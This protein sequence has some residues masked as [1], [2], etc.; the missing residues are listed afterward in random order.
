MS[1]ANEPDFA[2]CGSSI[3]PPCNGDYD[4]MVYTANE[5]VAWVKM[6]GPKLHT[7]GVKLMAPEPSEWLH[8]WSN[9]FLPRA[10][11]VASHQ[12]S[13]DPLGCGCFAND[14]TTTGCAS[15]CTTGGGYDYG[16]SGSPRI[17]RRG[18]CRHCGTH[19]Y[20]TQQALAWPSD[21]DGGKRSKEV[22][23]TEMSGVMYWPEQ[24][25]S[26]DINNGIAVA[27]W[28][29][30]ALVVGQASAWLYW[31]YQPSGPTTTRAWSP[32]AQ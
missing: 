10:R 19:E 7:A 27:G 16:H 26:S 4:T 5:M 29:H 28:I 6:L 25:R 31:W 24:G 11:S 32:R 18:A 17:R 22:W 8:L 12:N 9:A 23:E 21:V 14:P 2:S 13:S 30:S 3:G 1:A 20:D 15:K